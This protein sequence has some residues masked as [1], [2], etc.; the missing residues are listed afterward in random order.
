MLVGARTDEAERAPVEARPLG[1]EAADFH[2]ARGFRH[3]G[4]RSQ[5]QIGGD[6]V[7]ELLDAA[8]ADGLEHRLDIPAGVRDECHQSPSSAISFSYSAGL[9]SVALGAARRPYAH[10]PA[11]AEGVGID[12]FGLRGERRIAC[13]HL[14]RDGRVDIRGGLDRLHDRKGLTGRELAPGLGHLHE[15]QVAERMLGVIG[16]A[17]LH[18]AIGQGA[19]PFV[20]LRVLEIGGNVAHAALQT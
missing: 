3:A 16:D 4:E 9:R 6:L 15:H 20:G 2:F 12:G 8:D 18:R 19:Q 13:G 17:Y 5:P 10:Q 1:H 7:E 11:L 14:A